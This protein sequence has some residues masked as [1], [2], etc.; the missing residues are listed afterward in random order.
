VL[1]HVW[2]SSLMNWANGRTPLSSIGNEL[3]NAA[4]QLLA[5]RGAA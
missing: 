3:E 5:D 4:R 1:G 2:N